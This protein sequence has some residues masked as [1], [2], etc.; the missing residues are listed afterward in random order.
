MGVSQVLYRDR[1]P[2]PVET[3]P[4]VK[5]KR[6]GTILDADDGADK[7]LDCIALGYD[8]VLDRAND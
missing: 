7:C 1:K 5:C 3:P 2:L 4:P 8:E 6:C